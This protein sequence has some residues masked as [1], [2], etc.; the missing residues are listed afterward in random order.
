MPEHI[1]DTPVDSVTQDVVTAVA[2]A[3][4]RD[5]QALPPLYDAVDPD[6]LEALVNRPP[7]VGRG[8]TGV[9]VA[10]EF[11]DCVVTVSSTGDV[12]V[13]ATPAA[14]AAA[15]RLTAND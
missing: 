13:S 15:P 14:D 7:H 9:E 5:P 1:L 8:S 6:A 12:D 4:D 10:F 3:T 2:D 11:A